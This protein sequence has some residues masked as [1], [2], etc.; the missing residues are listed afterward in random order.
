MSRFRVVFEAPDNLFAKFY[1]ESNIALL[2]RQGVKI[3][4]VVKL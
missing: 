1:N 3:I 4:E 2:E